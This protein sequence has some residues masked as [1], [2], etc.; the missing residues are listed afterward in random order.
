MPSMQTPWAA[1]T[2]IAP[3]ARRS[4]PARRN[5]DS[6]QHSRSYTSAHARRHFSDVTDHHSIQSHRTVSPN[7]SMQAWLHCVPQN[8][9]MQA[10]VM[11][12]Q[13]S[14]TSLG[15]N[16]QSWSTKY[17]RLFE[18]RHIYTDIMA[19]RELRLYRASVYSTVLY[20]Y[21]YLYQSVSSLVRIDGES[22]ESTELRRGDGCRKRESQRERLQGAR[23]SE[24][25]CDLIPDTRCGMSNRSISY[26]HCPHNMRSRST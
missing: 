23:L 6:P 19:W 20:P 11:A 10:E 8:S 1:G 18:A 16:A 12:G 9:F 15:H 13:T 7:L 26:W 24:R 3:A 25:N 5:P 14:D 17:D 4:Q 22:C 21:V 2:Q